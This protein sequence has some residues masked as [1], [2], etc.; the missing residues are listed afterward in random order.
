MY[1][2]IYK[3]WIMITGWVLILVMSSLLLNQALYT[4]IHVMPNGS[5]I[6]HAHP[7]N[8]SNESKQGLPHQHT[9][10][11]FFLLQMFQFLFSMALL[12]MIL[13]VLIRELETIH[14]YNGAYIQ[15]I[16]SPL[17]GRAP[18]PLSFL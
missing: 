9:A 6:S 7:F 11:E 10:R 2:K 12:T 15:A 3:G 5:I 8:K 18:P 4:H 14:Y 13:K 17:A 1:W 16:F